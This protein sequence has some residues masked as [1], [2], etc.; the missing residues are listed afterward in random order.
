[1]D[2]RL[3]DIKLGYSCNNNCI[4]CVIAGH[5]ERL[6]NEKKPIDR[7]TAEVKELVLGAGKKGARSIT[8]TGGEATIRKD[9]FELLAFAAGRGFSV[10][11]QTNG[12]AFS[13]PS[14]AE[15]ALSIAPELKFVV[16]LHHT[17]GEAHDRITRAKG[18]WEQTVAGI[19]NII[20]LGGNVSLKVVLSKLN[21]RD[22]PALVLLAKK[23]GVKDMPVA[24]PHGMGNALKYWREVVP[25]Y[26]EILPYITKAVKLAEKNGMRLSYE[27]I[28]FCFLRGYESHAS[29]LD[30]L[31]DWLDSSTSKLRQVGEPEVDW[32]VE[33]LSIKRKTTK[34]RGCRYFNMCEGVW[35]E[36]FGFYGSG[37]FRPVAGKK[38]GSLADLRKALGI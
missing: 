26:T 17:K 23:M 2:V 7:T 5:R 31:Q 20:K 18:S 28:P 1:M 3:V 34:C 22:L 19:R 38:I 37:E 6:L 32:Q 16:A 29:E 24:F 14:F 36:Y 21:Y 11:L 25:S 30:Y 9:F 10:N 15:R 4:H 12:R 33:R 27:A 35:E 13:I 8:L